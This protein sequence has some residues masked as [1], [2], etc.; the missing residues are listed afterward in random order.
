MINASQADCHAS[1]GYPLRGL[2]VH[3]SLSG[4]RARN[5]NLRWRLATRKSAR[6][7]GCER[8]APSSLT[9]VFEFLETPETVRKLT[10]CRSVT[11]MDGFRL[12]AQFR[13]L[14]VLEEWGIVVVP[15]SEASVEQTAGVEGESSI[16]LR[17]R[18]CLENSER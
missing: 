17:L 3:A 4:P 7:H 15:A 2:E 14:V 1:A 16:P 5:Q 11:G 12:L 6:P 9:Q 10:L 18:I 13:L 8:C